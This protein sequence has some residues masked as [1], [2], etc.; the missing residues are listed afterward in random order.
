MKI[1]HI[2]DLATHRLAKHLTLVFTGNIFAAFLGFLAVLMISRQLTVSD[3][4]LFNMALSAM[5]IASRISGLGMD[6]AM[7]RLTSSYLGAHK[8]S[9]A[10][11]VLRTTFLI[12][13]I[14]SFIFA[15]IIFNTAELLAT[16]VSHYSSLTPLFK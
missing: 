1:T 7:I 3:F 9:E 4:G 16:K 12:K 11:Q 8:T 15:V 10:T 5:L 14:S 2:K 6:T 13:I